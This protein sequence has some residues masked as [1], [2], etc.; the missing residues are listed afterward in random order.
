[1]ADEKNSNLTDDQNFHVLLQSIT[2][3]QSSACDIGIKRQGKQSC[4]YEEE[5]D[6]SKNDDDD[7]ETL[8]IIKQ[9]TYVAR[10]SMVLIIHGLE[11]TA[12]YASHK[13]KYFG[14]LSSA[15]S[16][17][18]EENSLYQAP[19]H[20][21][22]QWERNMILMDLFIGNEGLYCNKRIAQEM[23]DICMETFDWLR[24]FANNNNK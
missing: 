3:L 21:L 12:S 23:F 7:G 6:K 15:V 4:I 22:L 24:S 17:L 19:K 16:C 2:D 14:S 1:M 13:S 20:L 5:C 10:F 18:R 8:K 11:L 9:T